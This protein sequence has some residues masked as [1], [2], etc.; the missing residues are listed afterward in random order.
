MDVRKD[1]YL[2]QTESQVARLMG[3][4]EREVTVIGELTGKL[5]DA[6]A[7][8]HSHKS[9]LQELIRLHEQIY[10]NFQEA[11]M[12]HVQLLNKKMGECGRGRVF[13][14]GHIFKQTLLQD[15]LNNLSSKSLEASSKRADRFCFLA[16]SFVLVKLTGFIQ[17]ESVVADETC[18]EH[19]IDQFISRSAQ[20]LHGGS[21]SGGEAARTTGPKKSSSVDF[22]F[23][24]NVN[25][26]SF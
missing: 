17:A 20:D 6:A 18:M 21:S 12:L 7:T 15:Y 13:L 22:Q 16:K 11:Y 14:S 26:K 25:K 5:E 1:E 8:P 10:K 24:L 2:S 9:K 3:L 23:V 4:L 19:P